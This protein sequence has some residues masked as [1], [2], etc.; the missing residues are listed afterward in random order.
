M[1]LIIQIPCYNEAETLA[2]ALAELPRQVEG[3]DV[4]EWLVIDDGSS[5]DTAAIARANGVDHVVRHS[6]NLGLARGFM[7][8]LNACLR[9]G[10]DVIV[11]TDADNQYNAADI[12]ALVA[13]VLEGRADIV[14]GARPI[15]TI[16]HFSPVKKLLQK[17]GSWVVRVASKTDIPDAPSGFRA[18]SRDAAQ[19]LIVFN[20]Y[21]YT[22]ETIIQAGQRG[23]PIVSVPVRVN[24]DLRPSRLVKSIPSYLRRSIATIIRIFVIYR[25][26][27]FF[28]IIGAVL[29]ALGTLIG[30]RYLW[31]FLE[32][33][34][35]GHVQSLILGSILL[36]MGF[37]TILIAFVADLLAANRRLMEE[38][39][40]L[41][42]KQ[43]Q[44]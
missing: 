13:P 34:G 18:I 33:S 6:V 44:A 4:V 11:N 35:E 26:F 3:F 2:I 41:Q 19:Q 29:F 14:V 5:D 42:K 16:E 20:N 32:G 1:K 21:T 7:T 27:R 24:G 9:L 12:P 36:G 10:A 17:L 8:G 15:A 40:Y 30:L 22:L 43:S 37:Q 23:I 25:P 39:R 38:V 31:F 28:G